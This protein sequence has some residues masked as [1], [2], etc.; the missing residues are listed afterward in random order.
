VV[1]DDITPRDIGAQEYQIGVAD[2]FFADGFER[3]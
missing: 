1:Y 2:R 3:L